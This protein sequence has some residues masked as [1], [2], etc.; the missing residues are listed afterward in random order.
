MTTLKKYEIPPPKIIHYEAELRPDQPDEIDHLIDQVKKNA[1]LTK[2]NSNLLRFYAQCRENASFPVS[3]VMKQTGIPDKKGWRRSRRKLEQLSLITYRN[4]G[5]RDHFISVNWKAFSD[6]ANL[7][8]PL[9]TGGKGHGN[10]G[11]PFKKALD[12]IMRQADLTKKEYVETATLLSFLFP[13]DWKKIATA[14]IPKYKN[15]Y[16]SMKKGTAEYEY[17]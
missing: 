8:K 13:D 11:D 14:S 6:L 2:N 4:N 1:K 17:Y 16:Y 15:L 5:V 12:N 7:K 9:K 3:T 10:L